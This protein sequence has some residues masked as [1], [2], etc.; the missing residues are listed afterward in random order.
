MRL[1]S[2]RY[3]ILRSHAS[4]DDAMLEQLRRAL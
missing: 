1:E 2:Q 4:A 3:L